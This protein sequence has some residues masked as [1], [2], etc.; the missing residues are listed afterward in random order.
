MQSLLHNKYNARSA[1]HTSSDYR[2][3]GV[4]SGMSGSGTMQGFTLI[5]VAIFCITL[6][7]AVGNFFLVRTQ[8]QV[9]SDFAALSAARVIQQGSDGCAMATRIAQQHGGYLDT[10]VRDGD[11]VQVRVS[12]PYAGGLVAGF[13]VPTIAR[14]GPDTS[15][16]PAGE[17]A[18]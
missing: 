15:C 1:T 16:I 4:Q 10:C 3:S 17:A 13:R 9:A 6:V 14:A 12:L 7:S 2:A 18:N 11:E 5:L 8:C